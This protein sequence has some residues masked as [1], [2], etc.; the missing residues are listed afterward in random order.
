MHRF[1]LT[2]PLPCDFAHWRTRLTQSGQ[3]GAYRQADGRLGRALRLAQGLRYVELEP[4]AGSAQCQVS[5]HGGSHAE[6]AE[7]R[8]I[9]SHV[10]SLDTDLTEF[11]THCRTT[12]PGMTPVIEGLAGARMIR[13][14]DTFT[15]V[16]DAMISQQLNLAFAA[17][18]KRRLWSL[19]G[20][21][22]EVDGSVIYGDP[23][24][25]A[26]ASLNNGQLRDMQY[27]GRKAEYIIGFARQVASGAYSLE[28]LRHMDDETAIA[29]LSAVRGIG[30]W[31]AD[32]VLLFGLGRQDLLPAGD[33]GLLR[34]A[35]RMW[36][37][38]ERMGEPA[39]RERSAPWSPWRSW[40]T[41]Y[42]WLYDGSWSAS[43]TEAE[44]GR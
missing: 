26:I 11:Y 24:P 22:L 4:Q 9:L 17:E 18:L 42:L 19:C 12:E 41:Y 35:S 32:C 39:L 16:I 23:T 36:R 10:L 37:L 14:A 28:E 30:R 5:I 44:H 25:E 40:Y 7:T 31:T 38:A 13:E 43:R 33:I 3:Q 1:I 2:I 6:E 8:Q 15:S 21:Y 20:E 29:S 34:S 27:S